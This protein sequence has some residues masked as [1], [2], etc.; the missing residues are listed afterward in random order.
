[1]FITTV[2]IP[3][4]I[5]IKYTERKTKINNGFVLTVHTVMSLRFV[6]SFHKYVIHWHPSQSDHQPD[7]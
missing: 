3:Q 1:M 7:N 5:L 2:L 4:N 6:P